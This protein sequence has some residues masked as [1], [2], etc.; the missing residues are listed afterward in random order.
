MALEAKHV[1]VSGVVQGVGFRPFVY[2]LAHDRELTGWVLNDQSGVEIHAEGQSEALNDFLR[3]IQLNPPPAASIASLELKP[4]QL[5]GFAEFVIRESVKRARPT[6]G[7]SPDLPICDECLGEL[8]DPQDRRFQYPYI[9][10][11]N[12]GPRYSIVLSLPY[13]RA[14]TTM[15]QWPMCDYC[16]AEYHDPRNRR[17]HAQPVAC[18]ACGPNYYLHTGTS[19]IGGNDGVREA[20]AL[21]EAGAIVAIKSLGGY[22]LACDARAATSV[23]AM[24]ER[25]YRKDR[26]FALMVRDIGVAQQLV[27]LTPGS[28]ELLTSTQRPIVLVLAKADLNAVA[29]DNRDLGIMLPYTPLQH[30]LFAAGAPS[31]LVMTSAN[32][33]SEPIAFKDREALEQLAGIAD[34]FLIGEREIA[35]RIDDSVTS[36]GSFGVTVLRHARGYAPRCVATLPTQ[37]PIL[38]LGADL[39]NAITLVVDGQAF[40][41]QHIGD[42]EHYGALASFKETARDLCAMYKVPVEDA[43][44]VHDAHPE[45]ASTSY[46]LS[47][48]GEHFAVQHHRAHIASVLAEHEAFDSNVVGVAFDGTGY[49]DDG[50]IWGGEIFVGNLTDGFIRAFSLASALLPGGDAAARFPVQAAAGFTSQLATVP[51]LTAP[52]FNF[53]PRYRAALQLIEKRVRVFS[54]TSVGRLF[55]AVA[56]L[57]G[58]TRE[59]SFEAQAAMWLEHIAQNSSPVPAYPFPL[60]GNT[61]DFRPLLSA[62]IADRLAGRNVAEIARAFHLAV[63][64][65]VADACDATKQRRV[66]LSGGVFQNA[67]LLDLLFERLAERIWINHKVSANDGGISLGQ[68][69]VAALTQTKA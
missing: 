33:S 60:Q 27:Y 47:L 52:P 63:A 21:L 44:I 4:A 65:G 43:L 62:V 9:N 51:D 11:T 59:I 17:F 25:K 12:C 49:G 50:T 64:Q 29:P 22:H 10:C 58:F 2:R 57:L 41:S 56:A 68:A 6:V 5:Q 23:L 7:L 37:R 20:A 16:S 31:A 15:Q 28:K 32:R 48:P 53:P 46:A 19:D 8:F 30:L 61:L 36:A 34:A 26:P 24:R 35:R 13:D 3:S 54:T 67:L 1:R 39:K 42:L 66:V 38:A 40:V 14:R 55:D 18:P 45:Y 69:A